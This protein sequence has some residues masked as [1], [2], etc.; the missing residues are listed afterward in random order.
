MT[1]LAWTFLR[2]GG[3]LRPALLA[4]AGA[5]ATALVLVAVAIL[6]LP[7]NPREG[8]FNLVAEEGLRGGTAFGTLLFVLPILLLVQQV[9]RL[10]TANRERRLA[11]LRLAGATAGQVRR[12]GMVEVGLPVAA[13]A[14]LGPAL[15][16]LLRATVGGSARTGGGMQTLSINSDGSTI[17]AVSYS[18]GSPLDLVPTSV[19]PSWWMA[20]LVIVGVA[21]AG[22]LTGALAS[23]QVVATPL[24]T[25][26]QAPRR[27]PRPWAGLLLAAL[28]L[29]L[30]A[31]AIQVPALDDEVPA[32]A[33][34]LLVLVGA[35]LLSP[36]VAH[37]AGARVL[38]RT[39]SPSRLV[40]AA[41]LSADPRPAGRAAAAVGAVGLVSGA[42]AGIEADVFVGTSGRGLDSFFVGSF[43][44]VGAGLLVALLVSTTTLAVHAIETM[45]DR[46]RALA[47]LVA[48]GTPVSLLRDSLRQEATLT[49][50]PL[51][52]GGAAV[53]AA[54]V[55]IVMGEFSPAGL[56]IAVAQVLATVLLT[57]VA[58]RTAVALV[59]PTL[60]RVATAEN[61]R[62][63]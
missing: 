5:V 25:S 18:T 53:G 11:A 31:V 13:G 46:K 2:A 61:L 40:A 42:C 12:V 10:G 15:F 6:L 32:M 33:G 3:A 37:R 58:I 51:A 63:E 26:R 21:G 34:I 62:T 60:R 1:R 56:L 19:G 35:V 48:A 7:A 24:G 44:L 23:R 52:L 49:A 50:L 36:W 39:S 43:L 55:T 17:S 14:L 8:L 30:M 29:V 47:G 38:A 27:P 41:R 16:L 4:V 28:G 54:L 57:L 22:T 9:V 59:T 45:V 20:A